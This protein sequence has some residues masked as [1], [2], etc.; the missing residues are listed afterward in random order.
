MDYLKLVF[1]VTLIIFFQLGSYCQ[2]LDHRKTNIFP[3]DGPTP[4]DLSNFTFTDSY[5]ASNSY[6]AAQ[7]TEDYVYHAQLKYTHPTNPDQSYELRVG[8]GGHIYSFLTSAG[9]TVPPQYPATAPWVDEVW[10]MVAVDGSLNDP[11]NNKK[12]FIHQAGVYLRTSEQTLPF[13]SPIIAEYHNNTD[14]SYTIVTWGQQAHT[15]DNI[16][17]GHTSAVLYYTRF[18]NL[19]DGVI[20]IDM[21]M[22]NFGND[23]IDFINIPWG[24]V[25]RSTYDH[26]FS[27]NTDHTYQEETGVYTSYSKALNTTG[28]W[29]AWSSD[30]AGNAP[31]LGLLMDNDEGTL[32]LG[33]AGTIA[34]RDYTVFEGIKFPGTDLGTGKAIR[35]RNF[36][37]LDSD[38]DDIKNTI[39]NK[40]LDNETFYGSLN[41]APNEVDSTAY[42]LEYQ[43]SE[44]IVTEVN[45]T[46][47]L[48]LKLRPYQNSKPLFLIKS[49][50][51]EFRITSDL[52]TYSENPYD[53]KLDTIQ[54]L[55]FRDD[56]TK[57]EITSAIICSGE[58][59]TFP[60]GTV[61]SNITATTYQVSDAGT[62][63]NGYDSLIFT[64]VYV[65]LSDVPPTTFVNNGPG[66]VGST[67]G[68]SFLAVWLDAGHLLGTTTANPSNGTS[69]GEWADLS[70]NGDDYKSTAPNQPTFNSSGIFNALTFNAAAT[71]PQFLTGTNTNNQPYGAV[72][73]ALNAT[74]AGNNNPLLSNSD[75]SLKYEQNTNSGFLGYTDIGSSD[76][77]STLAATFGTNNIISF[78]AHCANNFLTIH[79]GNSTTNLNIGATTNGIP[80]GQLGTSTE[81]IS[82][83]F[84]EIIAFK[85]NLNTAQK[86]LV[87]N[88]LSAKYGNIAISND[89]YDEDNALNGDFDHDVAGI[90]RINA[91]NIHNDAKGNGVIRINNPSNLGDNEFL[92]WGDN[93]QALAFTNTTDL[94]TTII[95]K[96]EKIW[97]LSEVNTSNAS[98]DVGTVDLTFD[99]SGVILNKLDNVALVIDSDNDGSFADETIIKNT[100]VSKTDYEGQADVHFN[101][102]DLQDGKRFCL[103]YLPPE[104]PG[105]IYSNLALWLAADGQVT[106]DGNKVGSWFDKS[107]NEKL[108]TGGL[109]PIFSTSSSKLLNYNPVMTLDGID[110]QFQ[111]TS[112]IGSQTYTDLNIFI[113]HRLNAAYHQSTLIRE[114]V[115]GGSISSHLPW[116]NG[117]VFWDAGISSGNGRINTLSGLAVGDD[118]MWQLSNHDGATDNQYIRKNGK[119]LNSDNTAISITGTSSSFYM[120]STGSGLYSNGDIAEVIAFAGNDE[121]TANQLQQIETYLAVKYGYTLDN[122]AG[123]TAGDYLNSSGVTIWDA[124]NN[125]TYHNEIIGISKDDA[126]DLHQKQS[127]NR[128]DSVSVY[129]ESLAAYNG[130]N[131]NVITNDLSSLLIG[132]NQGYLNDPTQGMNSEKPA[133]IFARFQREWKVTNTNFTDNFA[134]K[135]ACSGCGIFDINDIRLLV[136]EDGDFT[137]ATIYGNPTASISAGAIV[138]SGISTSV[139]PMNSTKYFTIGSVNPATSLLPVE[140]LSFHAVVKD[141]VVH[142][143]WQT[144]SEKENDYFTVERSQEGIS[145]EAVS[146]INAIGNS[147]QIQH[148]ETIDESPYIGQS[149]YRLKQTDTDGQFSYSSIRPI[150]LIPFEQNVRIYPNP[151]N[152]QITIEGNEEELKTIRIFNVLGQEVTKFT[153]IVGQVSLF[154]MDLSALP[155]G[156]YTI[157]TRSRVVKVV[158]R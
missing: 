120:G 39:I 84:Y 31:S 111:T 28:G 68:G 108:A 96:T 113:V 106:I 158:K 85:D 17:S 56:A 146:V 131:A 27:S 58:N 138:I 107:E 38:I 89:L 59:Y 21:L 112:I 66:G 72:F 87:D 133:G 151:T 105:G 24:G 71:D 141:K 37:I 157:N 20:Q 75:F 64:T 12:Y 2:I 119:T 49:T 1:T 53:G 51:D 134:I 147:H 91:N 77:T 45:Y 81:R 128:D 19:G 153:N 14:N 125:S 3:D 46:N 70:G 121:L 101:G 142:L 100:S 36:Y 154:V 54:L 23:N 67:N 6:W 52:Y 83:D 5:I 130:L 94:P 43:G 76:Y 143:D 7:F 10:Q 57:V 93:G 150:Y 9:E 65:T 129:I 155:S 126:S 63:H 99:L 116:S 42:S 34:N 44:L 30:A 88:Y 33:D 48:Q 144:A 40:G 73:M 152:H 139:I 145:W 137:N 132:H 86:I 90:G 74:D 122:T 8:K 127:N 47:G 60:D 15:A 114:S 79:S 140:L 148:Y 11:T 118:A 136:D 18:K 123:G 135:M 78:H 110:D 109:G 26:W 149:Y 55:G 102:I 124:D 104:G 13:Y 82:G 69:I 103:G 61:T 115:S 92:I 4:T 80:L 62:A 50:E 41:K 98:I 117:R 95:S 156:F 22:Y 29:A 16:N 97:R 32:R 25:R 35:A